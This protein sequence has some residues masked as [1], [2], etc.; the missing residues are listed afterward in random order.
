MIVATANL[1][2]DAE[3]TK[4]NI[5]PGTKDSLGLLFVPPRAMI[6]AYETGTYSVASFNSDYRDFL[7]EQ[8]NSNRNRFLKIIA[9]KSLILLTERE[10]AQILYRAWA[11][12][13]LDALCKQHNI[14]SS[15][16]GDIPELG[17]GI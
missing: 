6:E 16:I 13:F 7:R 10:G 9:F 17:M 8:F 1:S 5:G 15:Y 3:T 4:I 11:G 2:Y 14:K 12:E